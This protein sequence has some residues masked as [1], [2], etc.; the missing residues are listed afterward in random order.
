MKNFK[1]AYEFVKGQNPIY[2]EPSSDFLFL[3][4]HDKGNYEIAKIQNNINIPFK[5]TLPS[6][7][8]INCLSQKDLLN[9]NLDNVAWEGNWYNVFRASLEK[10][11]RA[12]IVLNLDTVLKELEKYKKHFKD[13]YIVLDFSSDKGKEYTNIKEI[14]NMKKGFTIEL[15]L[16]IR[17]KDYFNI[18]YDY[19]FFIA[20]DIKPFYNA[21]KKHSRIKN[22]YNKTELI[23]FFDFNYIEIRTSDNDCNLY[24]SFIKI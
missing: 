1:K 12:D 3:I 11:I 15:N 18:Q 7:L 14:S 6:C 5:K 10:N 2:V 20:V 8:N 23:A 9:L 22:K 19:S 16:P 21:L 17:A 4:N 13:S 24:Y